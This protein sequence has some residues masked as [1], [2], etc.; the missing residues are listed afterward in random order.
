MNLV[1]PYKNIKQYYRISLEPF[2]LNSDIQL[3]LKMELIK[4]VGKKCNKHGYIDEVYRIL[5]YSDGMIPPEYMNGCVVY[6]ITYHCKMCY[7][8]ENTIIIGLIKVIN[9]ELIIAKNGPISIFIPKENIDS[10]WESVDGYKKNKRK[11][12]IDDY[13]KIQ[14]VNKKINENDTQIR[15]IGVLIDYTTLEEVEKYFGSKIVKNTSD[16]ETTSDVIE[17]IDSN[18]II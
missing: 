18:F 9:Q 7:P 5:S 8:I 11:L 3:N 14:I 10:S 6:N 4:K 12:I 13:V 16:I 2:L 15:A 1:S 17:T